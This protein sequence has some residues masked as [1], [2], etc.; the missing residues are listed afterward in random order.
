MRTDLL[1]WLESRTPASTALLLALSASPAFGQ[2]YSVSPSSGSF[3]SIVSAGSAVS[4]DNTDD[5][6]GTISL[7]FAVEFF[8]QT[9]SAG[10]SVY[11]STNGLLV[12]D[13]P[14]VAYENTIIPSSTA[15]NGF[16]APLWDDL[17]TGSGGIYYASVGSFGSRTFVVEWS[18]VSPYGG[19]S[20]LSFQVRFSE[21][22]DVI[23]LAYASV[24]AAFAATIGI[25]SSDGFAGGQLP[26]SP[27]CT[28]TDI[29]SASRVVLTPGGVIPGSGPNLTGS[30][31]STLPPV[32]NPGDFITLEFEIRNSG[33][34][35]ASASELALVGSADPTI[36]SSDMVL[37][38]YS[39]STLNPG[40]SDYP[41]FEVTIPSELP[42]VPSG[43]LY[44]GALIDSTRAVSE[45]NEADN[46]IYL[47]SVQLGGGGDPVQIITSSLPS[48]RVGSSYSA[49]LRASPIASWM[50]VSGSIP[51]LSLSS[52][53]TLSGVP[54][55]PGSFA[56]RVQA[57]ASG[58][59][60]STADFV[61]QV[62]DAGGLAI[63]TTTLPTAFV[64]V[65]YDATVTAAGGDGQYAFQLISEAPSWLMLTRQ[66]R[67]TGTP[68]ESGVVS[69]SIAVTDGT[70]QQ[71]TTVLTLVVRGS[72]ELT[73][74]TESLPAGAVGA[75][76]S[77]TISA[78]GGQPPYSFRVASGALP[79]GISLSSE[80][81]LSGTPT[82][83]ASASPR[84][85][86]SD[87]AGATA[88]RDFTL[89]VVEGGQLRIT[90]PAEIVVPLNGDANVRLTAEGGVPPYSWGLQGAL[91][92]GLILN[93]E[94]AA[95][96]GVATSS[97]ATHV[98]LTVRDSEAATAML[99]VSVRATQRPRGA[100]SARGRAEPGCGCKTHGDPR[101]SSALFGLLLAFLFLARRGTQST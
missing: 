33:D 30:L 60:P 83:R 88:S 82:A 36:D 22:S 2:S 90:V 34:Q 58:Y 19:T 62:A 89:E 70:F 14:D 3:S 57:T 41:Y 16:I 5:G 37:Q 45:S 12:F 7:P 59:S 4:V 44:V 11:P 71:A 95:I 66:G 67:I 78:E 96:T 72:N 69:L 64:D 91:P 15:P 92:A 76:Y 50:I 40:A 80:G 68:T 47:G 97:I 20:P 79:D 55:Q 85:E 52:A 101:S 99:E 9:Y 26:C 81:A 43:T 65:P 87:A 29:L 100:S 46:V 94:L 35:L 63:T 98:V 93:T 48:G 24:S 75:R 61:V 8:G 74:V 73:I 28:S 17:I 54:S 6:Y 31:L 25:E 86:V 13:S 18:N 51:G 38:T 84:I 53:G 1:R 77:A 32:L 42:T 27:S 23:E 49:D 39:V 10:S 56:I 21:T